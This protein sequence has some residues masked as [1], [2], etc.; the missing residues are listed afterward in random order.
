V[1][2]MLIDDQGFDE[3]LNLVLDDAVLVGQVTKTQKE[4]TR[5]PLG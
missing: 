2:E 3:F 4:E 5:K 1:E